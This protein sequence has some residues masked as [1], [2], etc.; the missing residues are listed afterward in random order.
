MRTDASAES[1]AKL[2]L[3]SSVAGTVTAGNASTINDGAV[4]VVVMSKSRATDLGLSWI[5][6][7]GAHGGVAGP[8][9]TLQMHL[10]RRA[11]LRPLR[12][13]GGAPKCSPMP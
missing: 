2:R 1:L 10:Q 6:E 9:S 4:A 3:A 8:D 13:G 11:T 12:S 5:A 7:I